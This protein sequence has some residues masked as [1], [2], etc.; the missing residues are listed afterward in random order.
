[1]RHA[2]VTQ[3]Q[4]QIRRAVGPEVVTLLAKQAGD[5]LQL[6]RDMALLCAQQTALVTQQ[7]VDRR[8]L[9]RMR[10]HWNDQGVLARLAQLFVPLKF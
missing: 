3:T 5:V 8:E 1:M 9:E 7:A 10:A 6:Q 4:R 2:T